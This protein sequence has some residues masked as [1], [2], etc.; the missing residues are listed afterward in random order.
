[1]GPRGYRPSADNG[2]TRRSRRC[3]GAKA[4]GA[5]Q[6]PRRSGARRGVARAG[7][8]GSHR[9]ARRSCS[10]RARA[11][12]RRLLYL[13]VIGPRALPQ[14]NVRDE[15][16]GFYR[17]VLMYC[18]SMH[19]VIEGNEFEMSIKRSVIA[20]VLLVVQARGRIFIENS[21]D[22]TAGGVAHRAARRAHR[23]R[24]GPRT[25]RACSTSPAAPR[26]G[27]PDASASPAGAA[28]YVAEGPHD[29]PREH[30]G[31]E[32]REQ[33]AD[34]DEH[35][36]C[37]CRAA[38]RRRTRRSGGEHLGRRGAGPDDGR[39]GLRDGHRRLDRR[40]R[41]RQPPATGRGAVGAMAGGGGSGA[42]CIGIVLSV[43]GAAATLPQASSGAAPRPS[44][45]S[46]RAACR[47]MFCLGRGS[48]RAAP[49]PP[50]AAAA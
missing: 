6:A 19:V 34:G 44:A 43:G 30:G 31:D 40:A 8:R 2:E 47:A 49:A 9:G 1:M 15:L 17:D 48:A 22:R 36:A 18:D 38:A 27:R 42:P 25:R 5:P 14:G 7:A 46:P 41:M 35:D 13:S 16:V 3:Y 32:H 23:R 29:D 10:A 45:A 37:A 33:P 26:R 21:L 20:N 11:L 12:G 39:R 24:C 50:I 28:A 4:N